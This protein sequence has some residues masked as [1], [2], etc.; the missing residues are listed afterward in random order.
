MPLIIFYLDFLQSWKEWSKVVTRWFLVLPPLGKRSLSEN[1]KV[2]CQMLGI[3]VRQ[4]VPI[5]PHRTMGL[6]GVA[7]WSRENR[8]AFQRAIWSSPLLKGTSA[9]ACNDPW[10]SP[11][12]NFSITSGPSC[13]CRFNA[14]GLFL[15]RHATRNSRPVPG[16]EYLEVAFQNRSFEVIRDA[17]A[18]PLQQLAQKIYK[19]CSFV[20]FSGDCH[21]KSDFF[22]TFS[23]RGRCESIWHLCEFLVMVPCSK[24]L[25]LPST[26]STKFGPKGSFKVGFNNSRRAN[27]KK[28]FSPLATV[29]SNVQRLF[30]LD[31][32]ELTGNVVSTGRWIGLW[33]HLLESARFVAVLCC[34]LCFW[35]IFTTT[36]VLRRSYMSCSSLGRNVWSI[37]FDF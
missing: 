2:L 4:H 17:E 6:S 35:N 16:A 15:G 32:P 27:R 19:S 9:A 3:E 7:S 12:W 11:P 8:Q 14:P 34:L 13:P 20:G 28:K 24:L 31:L 29:V 30:G 36:K 37:C 5:Y 25:L 21:G 33:V 22:T 1:T 18:V 26:T 10:I 23:G